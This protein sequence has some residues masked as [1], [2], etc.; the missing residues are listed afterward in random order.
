[1]R[2]MPILA[3]VLVLCCAGTA[4]SG[5]FLKPRKFYG[6]IPQESFSFRLGFFGGAT[7][8][9]M[10]NKLDAD[11]AGQHGVSYTNDFGNSVTFEGSYTYMLHPRFALRGTSSLSLLRSKSDG[12]FVPTIEQDSLLLQLD[13]EREFN[14]D[15]IM[16]DGSGIF[17]FTDAEVHEFQPYL[18]GGFSLAIPHAVYKETLVNHDYR[19]TH[20]RTNDTK[21]SLEAAVHGLL[22]AL[23]YL[24]NNFAFSVEGRYQIAQSKF[25][26]VISTPE[27]L[28]SVRFDVV[29][30][31]FY[32]NVGIARAF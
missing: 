24:T 5:P 16:L 12:Y 32:L 17:Y 25:P 30:T 15:L 10:W 11:V 1:M 4:F 22:G 6:P 27:G 29:Y 14:V 8:E 13:Y 3:V 31:G 2:R 20:A 23:Y 7:N 26:V 21:W 9:E 19:T 18:G 28:R